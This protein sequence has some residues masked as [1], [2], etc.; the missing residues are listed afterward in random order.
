MAHPTN[1]IR[2]TPVSQRIL[3]ESVESLTPDFMP[4]GSAPA[5][6]QSCP[7]CLSIEIEKL[8][9]EPSLPIKELVST[10]MVSKMVFYPG[11]NG[12]NSGVHIKSS[13]KT[14]GRGNQ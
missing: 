3:P 14:P 2:S 5:K 1:P 10:V 8:R 7:V 13:F 12:I 6:T 4:D 11:P 9:M